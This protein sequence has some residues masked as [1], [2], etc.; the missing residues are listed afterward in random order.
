MARWWHTAK[1][2][3]YLFLIDGFDDRLSLGTYRGK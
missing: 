3:V 2:F 1:V